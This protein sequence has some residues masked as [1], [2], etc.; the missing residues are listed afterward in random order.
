MNERMLMAIK[1]YDE[2]M[3]YLDDTRK[4]IKKNLILLGSLIFCVSALTLAYVI[5]FGV[6]P[7]SLWVAH[8]SVAIIIGLF[9]VFLMFAISV[10]FS[11]LK[12]YQN[13]M[14]FTKVHLKNVLLGKKKE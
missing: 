3:A 5:I 8:T 2:I 1:E 6:Y 9:I 4:K 12:Y 10:L 13:F 7:S 11:S 14:N